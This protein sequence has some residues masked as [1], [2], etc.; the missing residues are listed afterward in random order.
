MR[1]PTC[2]QEVESFS[3]SHN[4][5]LVNGVRERVGTTWDLSCCG[6]SIVDSEVIFD[7]D[8]AIPGELTPVRLT[9]KE[10]N[11]LLHWQDLIPAEE[12]SEDDR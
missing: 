1:C 2:N 8:H 4:F 9:D 5:I 12:F 6:A 3:L 10:G 7:H 11:V